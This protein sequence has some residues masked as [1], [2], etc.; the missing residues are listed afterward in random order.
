MATT[1]TYVIL[2]DKTVVWNLI[3]GGNTIYAANMVALQLFEINE[4][5][6]KQIDAFINNPNVL[7]L[8]AVTSE[9]K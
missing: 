3:K 1:T 5:T 2:T 7:F 8:K 6:V 9:S 4:L